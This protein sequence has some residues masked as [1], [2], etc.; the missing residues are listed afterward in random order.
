M[1]LTSSIAVATS[2]LAIVSLAS[3]PVHARGCYP[4]LAATIIVN[5]LRGGGTEKQAWQAAYEEGNFN[6]TESCYLQIKGVIAK[7]A[8]SCEQCREMALRQ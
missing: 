7:Y 2:S 1:K 5:V 3:T 8:Q 4:S 6:G